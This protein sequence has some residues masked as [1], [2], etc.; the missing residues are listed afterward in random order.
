M[1]AAEQG[2]ALA[3]VRL[4]SRSVVFFLRDADVYSYM[5]YRLAD[6]L[7][8]MRTEEAFEEERERINAFAKRRDDLAP[9]DAFVANW[10]IGQPLDM[11]EMARQYRE[12]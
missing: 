11:G 7:G 9:V 4:A 10:Q 12:I 8:Y 6:R 1:R 3:M 2:H 5:L